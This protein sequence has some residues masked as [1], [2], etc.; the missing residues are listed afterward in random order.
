M[1]TDMPIKSE[2]GFQV[3]DCSNYSKE[4]QMAKNSAPFLLK[5]SY[6]I[7][8]ALILITVSLGCSKSKSSSDGGG[9]V[10]GGPIDGGLVPPT[11][12]EIARMQGAYFR[13]GEI[14][15]GGTLSATAKNMKKNP[16]RPSLGEA[17]WQSVKYNDA[18]NIRMA[19]GRIYELPDS[20]MGTIYDKFL[21]GGYVGEVT[22]ATHDPSLVGGSIY[23]PVT[24]M[25]GYVT[26]AWALTEHT[27]NNPIVFELT[28]SENGWPVS[29]N[30]L[31]TR[32][33]CYRGV[34]MEQVYT[35]VVIPSYGTIRNFWIDTDDYYAG[36]SI[37]R[38]NGEDSWKFLYIRCG[39]GTGGV[40]NAT[41]LVAVPSRLTSVDGLKSWND[42][43]NTFN[44]DGGMMPVEGYCWGDN[45]YDT[46]LYFPLM[47]NG[48]YYD[49]M[50]HKPAS[51][52]NKVSAGFQPGIRP[53]TAN[54]KSTGAVLDC[55][56]SNFGIAELSDD[57]DNPVLQIKLNMLYG[58]ALYLSN[59]VTT[60]RGSTTGDFIA[61][62][63]Y[64]PYFEQVQCFSCICNPPAPC[65]QTLQT[66]DSPMCQDCYGAP[67]ENDTATFENWLNNTSKWKTLDPGARYAAY[68]SACKSD[69]TFAETQQL[70]FDYNAIPQKLDF[71][72]EYVHWSDLNSK[73]P[74]IFPEQ[75]VKTG[76]A[77]MVTMR[78]DCPPTST[79]K[80]YYTMDGSMPDTSSSTPYTGEFQIPVAGSQYVDENG[81]IIAPVVVVVKAIAVENDKGA[82][83]A[84]VATYDFRVE[85]AP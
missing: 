19:Y 29:I 26:D 13:V 5:C 31:A 84:V 76:Q 28:T 3:I 77:V 33:I 43:K 81:K 1:I 41:E 17:T 69:L 61:D 64:N 20:V 22:H 74:R 45:I 37:V 11:P 55:G 67:D 34:M 39:D 12:E 4:D 15:D 14:P 18:S 52:F 7:L 48:T 42:E 83:D 35:E 63:F 75:G 58:A 44:Y 2:F 21:D 71:L 49:D 66:D 60:K 85:Q 68:T 78:S 65:S 30:T 16:G 80:F 10:D 38:L 57:I 62:Y 47:S 32:G 54:P 53:G 51:L 70:A 23:I 27:V 25:A 50:R 73:P 9:T 36:E 82:S 79:C 56:M 72:F 6:P 40:D 8:L 46:G 59:Y 24:E